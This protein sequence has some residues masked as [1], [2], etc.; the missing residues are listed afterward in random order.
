[1]IFLNV[2]NEFKRVIAELSDAVEAWNKILLHFHTDSRSSF[3]ELI[4][5][6]KKEGEKIDIFATRLRRLLNNIKEQ[7]K[8]FNEIYLNFKLIRDL[9]RKYD[10][11]VQ[12]ILRWSEDEFKFDKIV[13]ELV[14]E[15]TRL[16]VRN[17][18]NSKFKASANNIK[19]KPMQR[20]SKMCWHYGITGHVKNKC[21]KFRNS[22]FPSDRQVQS[23]Y[24]DS[25][26]S[27]RDSSNFS[28]TVPRRRNRGAYQRGYRDH[29]HILLLVGG[30]PEILDTIR[31]LHRPV[32][33]EGP[34]FW[35]DLST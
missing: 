13:F 10:D 35:K 12:C 11:I 7:D 29:P 24:V 25:S 14:S 18:D 33:L 9:P 23:T 5:C 4:E 34:Q 31:D 28:P 16:T 26:P 2:E 27:S 32:I 22:R 1:M 30:F 15:D 3:T 8:N 20:F 21:R 17:Q 6:K 19:Y